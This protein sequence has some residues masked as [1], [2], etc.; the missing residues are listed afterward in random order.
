MPS[1]AVRV[2]T[3]WLMRLRVLISEGAEGPGR[4]GQLILPVSDSEG[5]G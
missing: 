2:N 1:E 3:S 5:I 4:I